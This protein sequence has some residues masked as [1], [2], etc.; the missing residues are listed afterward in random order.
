MLSHSNVEF[1][2]RC[3]LTRGCV[4]QVTGQLL[5]SVGLMLNIQC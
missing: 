3:A 4:T 2:E 1:N 5:V